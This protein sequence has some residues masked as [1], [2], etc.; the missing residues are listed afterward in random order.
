MTRALTLCGYGLIVV[1]AVALEIA[2]RRSG[3]FA[4]LAEALG[5][6][7]RRWP[8]RLL[9]QLGWLWLGWHLFVRVDWR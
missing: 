2:A 3:R 1:S 8:A 5:V 9:I 7:L 4:S 6:A